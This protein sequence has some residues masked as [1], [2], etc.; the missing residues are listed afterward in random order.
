MLSLVDS[1]AEEQMVTVVATVAAA[2]SAAMTA[3]VPVAMTVDALFAAVAEILILV[4]SAE[5][6]AAFGYWPA[7]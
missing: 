5:V 6:A 2:V 3:V 4:H 1:E 7:E